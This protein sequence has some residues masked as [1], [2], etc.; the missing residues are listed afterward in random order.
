MKVDIGD[1]NSTVV[2]IAFETKNIEITTQ[3]KSTGT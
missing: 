1:R 3:A 2:M